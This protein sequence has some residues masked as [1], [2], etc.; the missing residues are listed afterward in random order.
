MNKIEML[1][2][3]IETHPQFKE[4]SLAYD[5]IGKVLNCPIQKAKDIAKTHCN[6]LSFWAILKAGEQYNGSYSDFFKFCL[7]ENFCTEKGFI[8]DKA[9]ILSQLCIESKLVTY[10]DY[11]DIINPSIRLNPDKFYQIKIKANTRG[12]HFMACYIQDG[13]LYLSDTSYRGIGVKA[14]DYVNENNFQKISEVV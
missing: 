12:D 2:K 9:G 6:M 8:K 11:E 1:N 4:F 13:V 5:A 14:L 3:I 10:R 7:G